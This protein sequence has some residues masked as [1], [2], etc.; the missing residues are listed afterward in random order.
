M[1]PSLQQNLTSGVYVP[2]T[3]LQKAKTLIP[4]PLPGMG[5]IVHSAGTAFRLWAPHADYVSVVG[6]FNDWDIESDPLRKE[7]NN[8]WYGN[9][10]TAEVGAEY[11]YFIRNGNQTFLRIDPYARQVTSSVGN[12][13]VADP[14]FDWAGDD[15]QLP[16]YNEL[17]IY[18]LHMGT[19]GAS[20]GRLPVG[21]AAAIEKLDYLAGMGINAI[22]VMPIAEFAGDFSWG[23]NPSHPFAVKSIYGGPQAFKEFVKAA[24]RKG[25]AVIMDVVLNHFGPS[26]LDLWCF[27]GWSENGKG[28]IFF[29][30]DWRSWTPWGE[31]RPNYDRPEVRQFLIDNARMWL[32]EYHV[33]G[34][35][36]DSTLYIRTVNRHDH[37]S[38]GWQFLQELIREVRREFP[39]RILLAEDLQNVE[40]LS[41][42][43]E[44]NGCG[45]DAQW[46]A[47]FMAPLREEI[48]KL[49][50]AHRRMD[51]I[52]GSIQSTYNGD[53]WQRV[54]FT[55]SHDDVA[56]GKKRLPSAIDQANPSN[57]HARKRSTLAGALVFTTPGLPMLFQ[58]QELLQE[59]SFHDTVPQA[60]HHLDRFP[61]I[62]LMYRDLIHLRLNRE[63][64]TRG[65]CGRGLNVF[66]QN[67]MAKVLAFHRWDYGG[68]GDDVVVVANFQNSP[69][70]GYTVGFPRPGQWKL[71]FNSDWDGYSPDFGQVISTEVE[72]HP[73]AWDNLSA[74]GNI[75]LGP[76]SL[77]IFS[78]EK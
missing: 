72:A 63:G 11:R 78:Q 37:L 7:N 58:G 68:P 9:V 1:M 8:H 49:D 69:H 27:D 30:N 12:A 67:D 14:H 46:D 39:G 50:D 53:C 15:F 40:A 55:E 43:V 10:P 35:R 29:Y 77:L 56:N 41:Q 19:F 38:D 60:W 36:V 13:V 22:E 59:G 54:I 4:K 51:V 5:A 64:Q 73:G 17:V 28:G 23:Y 71:R 45:F 16:P 24:H 20:G 76:Y 21:F 18:E 32:E 3:K 25:I 66:H 42:P 26:D 65:L 34:L 47:R 61:G 2:E 62:V 74:H 75:N 48:C 44:H 70:T 57:W 6:T 33:D 52:R 31:T